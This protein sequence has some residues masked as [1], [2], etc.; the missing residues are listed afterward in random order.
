M[1][2]R[3]LL[4]GALLLQA[5]STQAALLVVTTTRDVHDGQCNKHCSLRDAV[6]VANQTPGPSIIQLPTGNFTLGIPSAPDGEQG[7]IEDDQDNQRGD[8]DVSGELQI[9]GSPISLTRII[10]YD[11][12]SAYQGNDDRLIEV[13]PGGN[14]TLEQLTLEAGFTPFEGG[15]V[16]NRGQLLVREVQLIGNVTYEERKYPHS[17]AYG[18]AIANYG[19]LTVLSSLFYSNDARVESAKQRTLGGAIYNRG[20][21][22]VRDS[23][24]YENRSIAGGVLYNMG[25]ATFERCAFAGNSSLYLPDWLHA[26]AVLVNYGGVL[27]LSNSTLTNN[28]GGVLSNGVAGDPSRHS[29]LT[30]SHVTITRN[31]PK[32]SAAHDLPRQVLLNWSELLIRNSLIVGNYDAWSTSSHEATNC[33]N[34]GDSF[35]YQAIGLLRNDESSNCGADLYVPLEKTFTEVLSHAAPNHGDYNF[36]HD[37]LPGSPAVD[38]G[39]GDCVGKDQRG[40]ARPQDGNGDGVAVCD[41]GAYELSPP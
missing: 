21:L 2:I 24:F 35:S 32:T 40:V 20:K 10:W 9:I 11:G 23:Q 39:I 6:A 18:G 25:N 28:V 4:L 33:A 38:A 34:L 19:T 3:P 5:F 13:L 29:K 41:L 22:R 15:A 36:T 27:T 8:L 1:P 12:G 7:I 17:R 37:L 14:L 30:L 26:D 16:K 31:E